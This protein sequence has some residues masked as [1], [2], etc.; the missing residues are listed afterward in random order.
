MSLLKTILEILYWLLLIYF[1]SPHDWYKVLKGMESG[2]IIPSYISESKDYST[3]Y[4]L[5]VYYK[6]FL[7]QKYKLKLIV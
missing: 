1:T 5:N 3:F 7:I 2:L 4:F 6:N